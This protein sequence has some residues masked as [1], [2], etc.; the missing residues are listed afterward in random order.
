MRIRILLTLAFMLSSSV[1]FS[2]PSVGYIG[3]YSDPDR[4]FCEVH[5][6]GGLSSFDLYVYCLPSE[7]GVMSVKFAISYPANV[8][9]SSLTVNPGIAYTQGDL[10]SGINVQFQSCMYGWVWTHHQ[11]LYITDTDPDWIYIV[12]HPGEGSYYFTTCI[13]G[14]PSEGVMVVNHLA[15]NQ[16][17][18]IATEETSWGAIKSLYKD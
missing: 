18:V 15:V 6:S 8:T 11:T 17:C 10:E 14:Y 16:P 7:H 9:Q 4:S 5:S 2:L 12:A 3:L 1:A 13:D